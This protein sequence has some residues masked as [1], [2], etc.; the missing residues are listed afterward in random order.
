MERLSELH[1]YHVGF[2]IAQPELDVCMH[3]IIAGKRGPRNVA[4][5]R[6]LNL[7]YLALRLPP[8]CC[9]FGQS[10]GAQD[11]QEQ[12]TEAVATGECSRC[13]IDGRVEPAYLA[14]SY[15]NT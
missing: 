10:F 3:A 15:V 2:C 1:V 8:P 13:V 14:V 11:D 12:F 7:M 5:N 4:L 6:R 9:L